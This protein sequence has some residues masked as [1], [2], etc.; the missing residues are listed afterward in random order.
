MNHMIKDCPLLKK[1]KGGAQKSNNKWLQNHF[2][3]AMKATWDETS[4]E[5]SEDEKGT[6]TD[7]NRKL[8]GTVSSLKAKISKMEG[9]VYSLKVENNKLEGTVSF[10]KAEILNIK[11]AQTESEDDPEID[12]NQFSIDKVS[13]LAQTEGTFKETDSLN[14]PSEPNHEQESLGGTNPETVVSAKEGID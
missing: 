4:D 11:K 9:I 2:K 8:E 5:E 6:L 12:H 10:L 1:N 13:T 14:V 3:K 7:E